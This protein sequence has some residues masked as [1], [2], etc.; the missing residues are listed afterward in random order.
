LFDVNE[1]VLAS[2]FNA[3]V[4]IVKDEEIAL[5]IVQNVPD[6]LGV[7]SERCQGNFNV[8][9]AKFGF[10]GAVGLITRNPNLL[11]IP[12][13]GY[14]SAEVAGQDAVVLSYLINLTRPVGKPL[15]FILLAL[16]LKPFVGPLIGL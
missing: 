12:T 4:S 2:R 13:T 14:G 15:I 5:Q 3:L 9:K 10:E 8:F 11:S 1:D 16:L 7:P 6:S